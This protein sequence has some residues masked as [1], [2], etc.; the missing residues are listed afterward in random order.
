MWIVTFI[1][2]VIKIDRPYKAGL[3]TGD[4]FP[5]NNSRDLTVSQVAGH[6]IHLLRATGVL[7]KIFKKV[8]YNEEI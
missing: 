8:N 4:L 3:F 6:T 5:P 1:S 2:S 7:E